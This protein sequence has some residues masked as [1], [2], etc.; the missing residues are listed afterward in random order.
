MT[1]R[2]PESP[3]RLLKA[4]NPIPLLQQAFVAYSN[5][6][7]QQAEGALDYILMDLPEAMPPL[8]EAR[9][10]IRRRIFGEAPLSLWELDQRFERIA[11][12]TRPKGVILVMSGLAM[13]LADLQTLRHSITK[14]R[15]SGKRV[16]VW[17]QAFDL[18]LYYVASAASEV[19]LQ[20]GGN[21]F[22]VGLRQDA[23]FFKEALETVGIEVESF[24]IS[25][26]KGALDS[27][28]LNDMSVEGREQADWLLDSRYN[29]I[30]SGI[31]EGRG[32][33]QEKAND[34]ID[35]APYLDT[36]AKGIGVVDALLFQEE[37]NKYL[38]THAIVTWEDADDKLL[39]KFRRPQEKYIAILK[40]EGLMVT[41]ES[42]SPPGDIPI[43]LPIVD[44][45]RVGDVT[46]VGQ[47]RALMEDK[48]AAA[49]VL[50]IDSGGGSAD[51]AESMYSALLELA[52]DRPLI[53]Y[54]N[55]VAASGGYMV[56]APA[57]RIVAQPGTIT[58][59]IGVVA[60]RISATVLRDRLKINAVGLQRG[61]NANILSPNEPL[62]RE[63][64]EW[65]GQSITRAYD[66]FLDIVAKGRGIPKEDVDAVAGGRVWT[67]E[68]A[69][70]HKLI[71]QLGGLRDAI[72]A[73]CELAGIP[74]DSPVAVVTDKPK[75][76][77]PA[78]AETA[79]PAAYLRYAERGL[80][81][82]GAG[83]PLVWMPFVIETR[84]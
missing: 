35:N 36:F 43:P 52:K 82:I 84:G 54:M 63:Q 50:F 44:D 56:A 55:G 53:A 2:T 34:V 71:D 45:G 78:I 68:Q 38:Q 72:A 4:L 33:T 40:V 64:R 10:L 27:F 65:F 23:L 75:A 42:A 73:A 1:Q 22:T 3:R 13:S 81:V 8:P 9:G 19:I 29:Q 20:P 66:L 37:L 74:A 14:L 60:A 26:Y 46:L 67:G 48:D 39:I 70:E 61:R 62:S 79:N 28:T 80:T 57:R 59:S 31:A 41:G 24:A 11:A 25:P 58:G 15:D 6:R 49:V 51:A 32:W 16:I 21:L 5:N 47:V 30:I 76:L 83:R 18:A 77:A 7:R 69:L 12:D 17:A